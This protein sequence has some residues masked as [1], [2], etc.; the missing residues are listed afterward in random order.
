MTPMERMDT[1]RY[2]VS[3]QMNAMMDGLAHVL[4]LLGAAG[5]GHRTLDADAQMVTI[6]AVC[7][8]STKASD[9]SPVVRFA[10]KMSGLKAPMKMMAMMPMSRGTNFEMVMTAL[11]RVTSL[12]PQLARKA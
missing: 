4:R 12:M 3:T 1:V 10:M 8:W 11:M 2:S 7:T 5:D 9:G 6:M